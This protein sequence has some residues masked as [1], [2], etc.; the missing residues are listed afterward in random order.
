LLEGVPAVFDRIFSSF[1]P[2]AGRPWEFS[3]Q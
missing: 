1:H 3:L 2:R